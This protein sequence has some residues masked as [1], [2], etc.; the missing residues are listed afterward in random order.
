MVFIRCRGRMKGGILALAVLLVAGCST[1]ASDLS[2]EGKLLCSV[3]FTEG[4]FTGHPKGRT[5]IFFILQN[6]PMGSGEALTG[7]SYKDGAFIESVGGGSESIKIAEA[8]AAIGF[9]PFDFEQ[10]VKAAEAKIHR[11]PDKDGLIHGPPGTLDGAEYEITIVTDKGMFKMRRWNPGPII[12][13]YAAHSTKIA[14][15]K[16]VIDTLA[17]YYGRE[18]F[19]L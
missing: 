13:Y 5:G 8:D 18:K 11:L 12:D 17:R 7:F 15:L 19:G 14:K 9:E 10:E 1:A 6:L 2:G 4:A 3:E 16:Q